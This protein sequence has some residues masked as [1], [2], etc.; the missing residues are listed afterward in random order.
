VFRFGSQCLPGFNGTGA[1]NRFTPCTDIDECQTN[2]GGWSV[3][4]PCPRVVGIATGLTPCVIASLHSSLYT[5]CINLVGSFYCGERAC[6][7]RLTRIQIA[8]V[9][10]WSL[11]LNF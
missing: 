6:C 3:S 5:N 9:F 2:H 4:F 8:F 7:W 10:L 1:G 11:V